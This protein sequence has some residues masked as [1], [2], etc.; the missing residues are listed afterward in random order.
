MDNRHGAAP[1]ALARNAPVA[2]AVLRFRL[3]RRS[4]LQLGGD[5]IEGSLKIQTVEFVAVYQHAVFLVGIPVLPLRHV[6]RLAVHANH[7]FNRQMILFGKGKIALVMRGHGHHRAVAV[8]PQHIVRHPHFQPLAVERVDDEAAGG[9]AFFL[10]GR[11]IGFRHAAGLAFGNERLQCRLL[12]GCGGGQRML[13]GHGHIRRAHQRVGAGGVHLHKLAVAF[14]QPFAAVGGYLKTHGHA[15][16]FANPV[17]L[18]GFHL[19]RPVQTV[20]IGQQLLGV[21]GDFEVV[22]RDFAFF[23][24]CAG[25]PA[26]PV[27][28]LLVRQHG[29]VNRVPV[30]RAQLFV[31]NAFFKQLGKQELLP[32]VVFGA[33]GGD[34]ALPIQRKAQALQLLAHIGNVFIRPFGRRDL[35]VNRRV[36]GGHAERVPTHRLQHVEPLHFFEAAAHVA[37]GVVAHMPHV[38]LAAGIGEHGEAVKFGFG[39][40]FGHIERAFGR[41]FPLRGGLDGGGLVEFLHDGF[42]IDNKKRCII[43]VYAVKKCRLLCLF[44]KSSLHFLQQIQISAESNL[45][46]PCRC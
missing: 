27:N 42:L 30:H 45:C 36:F 23:H 26:A 24:Q 33:A 44:N 2:Q 32:A 31:H 11:H 40:V 6:K 19:L 39:S 9:H 15:A 12:F 5:G 17:A 29:L 3:A 25:T 22:H 8:A 14:R 28:H 41:P 46:T 16:R 7:L 21:I 10:H 18:H 35:V 37:D 20:Q 1:I 38:Q 13:G 4:S 43:A 34:F